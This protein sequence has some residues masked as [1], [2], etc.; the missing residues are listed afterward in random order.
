MQNC[1]THPPP[2]KN[3]WIMLPVLLLGGSYLAYE[4]TESLGEK[5]EEMGNE[6]IKRIKYIE[7]KEKQL[8]YLKMH[9]SELQSELDTKNEEM[10]DLR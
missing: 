6:K 7:E 5:L 8:N 10:N 4:G 9:I 3:A 1:L 2:K